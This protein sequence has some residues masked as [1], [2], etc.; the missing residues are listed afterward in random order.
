MKKNNLLL[1][2]LL[3]ILTLGACDIISGDGTSNLPGTWDIA[4]ITQKNYT[5]GSLDSTDIQND[6]GEF[7]FK[8]GG[9][10]NYS[11][12][13]G[14]ETLSGT[15]DWFEQNDKVFINMLNITDSIMTKNFAVG[16]DVEANTATQQI[17]SVTYSYYEEEENPVSGNLIKYL[18]KSYVEWDLQKQ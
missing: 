4:S 1:L 17:W 3:S 6:M 2:A 11:I 13:D 16:F 5:N 9:E 10:G 18:K 15:F 7:T 12:K 14:E 8:S